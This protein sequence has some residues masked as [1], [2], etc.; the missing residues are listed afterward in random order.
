MTLRGALPVHIAAVL[1]LSDAP[2]SG[3]LQIHPEGE[4]VTILCG[5]TAEPVATFPKTT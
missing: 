4:T 2:L 1:D 5:N 3:A